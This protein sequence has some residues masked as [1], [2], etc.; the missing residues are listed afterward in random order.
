MMA[1][2]PAFAAWVPRLLSNATPGGSQSNGA[3]RSRPALVKNISFK[4]GAGQ[5]NKAL[6]TLTTVTSASAPRIA[7]TKS[8]GVTPMLTVCPAPIS[9]TRAAAASHIAREKSNSGSLSGFCRWM[10]MAESVPQ[11]RTGGDGILNAP[12]DDDDVVAPRGCRK[13]RRCAQ[14][15]CRPFGVSIV[16]GSNQIE[17]LQRSF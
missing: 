14:V 5:G 7:A 15:L 9:W 2:S 1:N 17:R 6:I 13:V 8:A 12:A 4:W 10:R 3:S 11:R 16:W